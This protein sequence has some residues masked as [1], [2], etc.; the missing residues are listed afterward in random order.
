VSEQIRTVQIESLGSVAALKP[1]IDALELANAAGAS[2]R[3]DLTPLDR[4]GAEH[5]RMPMAAGLLM[6]NLLL[7]C[8][9]RL[10]IEVTW[11][12]EA[13]SAALERV[14][15]P[16]AFA[17]RQGPTTFTGVSPRNWAQWQKDWR[18]RTESLWDE[19]EATQIERRTYVYINTHRLGRSHFRGYHEGAALPWLRKLVPVPKDPVAQRRR[20]AFVGLAERAVV[21]LNENVPEHAFDIKGNIANRNEWLLPAEIDGAS[22][23]TCSL[24]KGGANSWDRLHVMAMDNGYGIGRTMRWQHRDLKTPVDE[25]VQTILSKQLHQRG[26][27]GHNGIGLWWLNDLACTV[28]GEIQVITEDDLDPS[29]DS[30][31]AVDLQFEGDERYSKESSGRETTTSV[32]Q[33]PVPMRGTIVRAVLQ[34]PRSSE[35]IWN[36]PLADDRELVH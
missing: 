17:Q 33:L 11:P 4:D 23:V 35:N 31:V 21:E 36:R 6:S 26:I 13:V 20:E 10:P 14:G 12:S 25:L 22:L 5:R 30:C 24:T 28:G 16:F 15:L 9:G 18:P 34:V 27:Q 2:L 29:G 7:G 3:L 1:V 32:S 8:Y 19:F